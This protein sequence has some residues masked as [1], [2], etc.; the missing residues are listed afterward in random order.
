MHRLRVYMGR[1]AHRRRGLH[2]HM[3][4]SFQPWH[5]ASRPAREA[6]QNHLYE[7]IPSSLLGDAGLQP[8]HS[9]SRSA[10]EAIPDHLDEASPASLR[11]LLEDILEPIHALATG[12]DRTGQDT[13]TTSFASML[14]YMC[15]FS[16]TF[17]F[18]FIHPIHPSIHPSHP[19]EKRL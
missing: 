7:E 1:P 19:K 4:P 8:W 9:A 12:Q 3:E 15:F 14:A 2:G 5:S 18:A 11:S 17:T 10:R 16:F 13:K 6:I